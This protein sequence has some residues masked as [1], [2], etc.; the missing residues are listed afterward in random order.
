MQI[1]NL[2]DID[3]RVT[4]RI[5]ELVV[6]KLRDELL[7]YQMYKLAEIEQRLRNLETGASDAKK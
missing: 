6:R 4:D 7:D 1:T 2:G 5:V 3:R